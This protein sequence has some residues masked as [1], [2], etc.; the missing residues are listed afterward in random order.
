M[1]K[2]MRGHMGRARL[3][4]WGGMAI[5]TVCSLLAASARSD[6]VRRTDEALECAQRLLDRGRLEEAAAVLTALTQQDPGCPRAHAALAEVRSTQG[7]E[8]AAM[9]QYRAVVELC[10][11]D[12]EACYDLVACALALGRY[13]TAEE[14]LTQR[15]QKAPRDTYARLLLA[16]AH[17][18]QEQL[19]KAIA[20]LES[21]GELAPRDGAVARI[22]ARTRER[23]QQHSDQAGG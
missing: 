13:S 20:E 16:Y 18:R 3:L 8:A 23:L 4:L 2:A 21:T 1:L 5:V 19:D 11:D 7:R 22:I 12:A 9:E 6:R 15:I 10:P 14:Y 17:K